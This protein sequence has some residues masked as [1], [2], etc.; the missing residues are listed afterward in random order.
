MKDAHFQYTN[1]KMWG[2][3]VQLFADF[4]KSNSINILCFWGALLTEAVQ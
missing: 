4:F 1:I 3:T 2:Y